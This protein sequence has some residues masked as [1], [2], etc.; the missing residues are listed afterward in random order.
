[1]GRK[2][3]KRR[4]KCTMHGHIC[5][6]PRVSPCMTQCGYVRAHASAYIGTLC[7]RHA[8]LCAHSSRR[9][10]ALATAQKASCRADMPPHARRH[11]GLADIPSI[12]A[13]PQPPATYPSWM[14][15]TWQTYR[16]PFQA[17]LNGLL[18]PIFPS[19]F[20]FFHYQKKLRERKKKK[21]EV[22]ILARLFSSPPK[23]QI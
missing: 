21:K 1:M 14:V 4:R 2:D 10:C 16:A 18:L 5:V 15:A 23:R 6:G 3:K 19:I 11:V 13:L 22:G 9:P 17:Y 8:S 12:V 20:I 7:A